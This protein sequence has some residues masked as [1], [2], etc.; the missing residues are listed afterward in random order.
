MGIYTKPSLTVNAPVTK[1]LS[2]IACP[3][4][5]LK[6]TRLEAA[7]PT[8]QQQQQPQEPHPFQ[9]ATWTEAGIETSPSQYRTDGPVINK[10]MPPYPRWSTLGT[11]GLLAC[12]E[13]AAVIYAVQFFVKWRT[14]E[15]FR[16]EASA[17][18]LAAA[19]VGFLSL[20]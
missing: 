13:V 6:M 3:A 15:E 19:A 5:D 4:N 2:Q 11:R 18:G 20:S 17:Y 14:D 8:D 1:G 7:E 10:D 12:F 9:A 16:L